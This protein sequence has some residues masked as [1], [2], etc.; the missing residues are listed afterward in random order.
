M[1]YSTFSLEYALLHQGCSVVAGIDEV[2]RGCL[3]GPV[4]A[5]VVAI[6]APNDYLPGVFDSKL[7]SISAR[8]RMSDVIRKT[9]DGYGIGLATVEEIDALGIAKASALAMARAYGKLTRKPDIVII[10]GANIQSPV[11]HCLKIDKAD[12]K[13]YVVSAASVIAKVYRDRLMHDLASTYPG[14]G[15]EKHV[16]YGTKLH[17][18][19][20]RSHGVCDIHR[21]SYAPVRRV[22]DGEK[23]RDKV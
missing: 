2:G 7:M 19:A 17:M 3:A 13:H 1:N 5:G 11:L 21:K 8:E 23:V 4:V 6:S 15:F 20:L 9:V 16:G 10:D 14:Y 22:L 18:D 12:Q